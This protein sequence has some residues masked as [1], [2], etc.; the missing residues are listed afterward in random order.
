MAGRAGFCGIQEPRK[1]VP[2][3]VVAADDD[4]NLTSA[5]AAAG[6]F[7]PR[8]VYAETQQWLARNNSNA[9]VDLRIFV[10]ALQLHIAV[11]AKSLGLRR[12]DVQLAYRS[13][14]C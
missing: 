12:R 14:S 13:G 3:L 8:A 11:G 10:Y 9:D 1:V 5:T 4:M 7:L 6:A 2:L